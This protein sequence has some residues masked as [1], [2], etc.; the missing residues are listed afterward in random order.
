MACLQAM[1]PSSPP[2]SLDS[3]LSTHAKW[4]TMCSRL[5]AVLYL[6]FT[7]EQK[8]GLALSQVG[9]PLMS[10]SMG[11]VSASGP[12]FTCHACAQS[13][14]GFPGSCDFGGRQT[15]EKK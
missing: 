10:L 5:E 9:T 13:C 11:D 6:Q 4:Q 3:P 15:W 8:S 2:P 1:V 7:P 14:H 12:F